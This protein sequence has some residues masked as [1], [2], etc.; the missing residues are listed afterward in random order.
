MSNQQEVSFQMRHGSRYGRENKWYL[1]RE[2]SNGDTSTDG[3][4]EPGTVEEIHRKMR[5]ELGGEHHNTVRQVIE[6]GLEDHVIRACRDYVDEPSRE[7]LDAVLSAAAWSRDGYA[8]LDRTGCKVIRL[9]VDG[10]GELDGPMPAG[11]TIV[12]EQ[13]LR[14]QSYLQRDGTFRNGRS[15]YL[16]KTTEPLDIE[17]ELGSDAPPT[18]IRMR[19]DQAGS[20]TV[21]GD[22]PG[23]VTRSGQ[24]AGDA[25]RDGG[26]QGHA[27]RAGEGH[28]SANRAI[29]ITH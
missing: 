17:I 2:P 11:N 18:T 7:H 1:M 23:D 21:R 15:G 10:T 25:E 28:G 8:E 22:V 26:G 5:A 12:K 29:L 27:S 19:S 9:K 20:V 6:Q 3:M 24:G 4:Q 14:Y 16:I 13:D